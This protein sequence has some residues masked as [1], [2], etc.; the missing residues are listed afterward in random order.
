[1]TDDATTQAQKDLIYAIMSLDS[2]DRGYGAAA[3]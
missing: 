3:H 2:Y 1:M